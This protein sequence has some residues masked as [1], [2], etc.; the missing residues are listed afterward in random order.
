MGILRIC[1]DSPVFVDGAPL[2][3][4]ALN[5]IR[6]NL[7]A[8]DEGT[9]LGGVIFAGLYGQYPE[10]RDE[11]NQVIWS[12]GG[13]FRTGMTTLRITTNTTGTVL[14]GD[15]LRVYR[16][17]LAAD[18]A[19]PATFTDLALAA[20][21][22]THTVA[23]SGHADGEVLRIQVEVR[24]LSDPNPPYTGCK[25]DVVLAELLPVQLPD[26]PPTLPTF[27]AASDITGTKL[28]Q[29][30][31]YVD[32]L[33]RRVSL[34]YDPL[35]VIHFRRKG[36]FCIPDSS[37]NAS[38]GS[39]VNV[40]WRGG[41]RKTPLHTTL[42]IRG[43]T[44]RVWSGATE[45]IRLRLNGTV[46]QT[47]AVP[48]G[49]GESGF[50]ISHSLAA[51][52][53]DSVV[54]VALEYVRTAPRVDD[55][56]INRWTINEVLIEQAGA[57]PA[58]LVEWQIRQSGVSATALVSWLQAARTLAAA[59]AQRIADNGGL[60]ANQRLYTLR[61]GFDQSQ[62]EVFEAWAIPGTLR[63]AGEAL[64]GR[65]RALTLGYSAGYVDTAAYEE[66]AK[67][68]DGIGA[69]PVKNVRTSPVVD[70]DNVESFALYLDSVPGLPVGAPYNVRGVESYVLMER[71]KVV[72]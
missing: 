2:S 16:G 26:A 48:T 11:P 65:G 61:S 57:S 68:S 3:P 44:F 52:A 31:D 27:S 4:T 7:L 14:A 37:L 41:F 33:I 60:W 28:T 46:V 71:L 63:R 17:D 13:V 18:G 62:I 5:I 10:E 1:D 66:Q 9:R 49:L 22:Q 24:H 58:S 38:G 32:W 25:V 56:P 23:L 34:R 21:T 42:T 69:Y 53:T 50:T 36:P 30:A 54:R 20:G 51:Y 67:G 12:G 64:V 55:R 29:L 39:D 19:L 70:G 8:L 43:L 59:I 15:T 72:E 45:A 6:D 40:V 35:F 47:Y